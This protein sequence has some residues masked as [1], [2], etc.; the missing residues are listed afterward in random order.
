MACKSPKMTGKAYS[1]PATT[2]Q[3]LSFT[4]FIDKNLDPVSFKEAYTLHQHYKKR[5]KDRLEKNMISFTNTVPQMHT[6][7]NSIWF[8]YE[9]FK[10]F[11]NTLE[12]IKRVMDTD[13]VNC[14]DQYLSGVRIYFSA[15]PENYDSRRKLTLILCG[16]YAERSNPFVHYD[17]NFDKNGSKHLVALS[18]YY[19]HGHLCPPESCGG[20]S[21]DKE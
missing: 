16:T 5:F 14:G 17:L 6:Q 10:A 3:S 20:A 11:M 18:G 13:S 21:L 19:N 12:A 15:Y 2:I 1:A 9:K 8:S 4:S 7:S